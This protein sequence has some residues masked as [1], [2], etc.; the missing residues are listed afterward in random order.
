MGVED[1]QYMPNRELYL[2][3]KEW[4]FRRGNDERSSFENRWF[5][6]YVRECIMQFRRDA[7]Q[8]DYEP[9]KDKLLD[10]GA[11]DSCDEAEIDEND[12][13]AGEIHI[14]IYGDEVDD[15]GEIENKHQAQDRLGNE[16]AEGKKGGSGNNN[17]GQESRVKVDLGNSRGREPINT[18][19]HTN[20]KEYPPSGRRTSTRKGLE[21]EDESD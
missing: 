3:F 11:P 1:G 7:L 13:K 2:E 17:R 5:F 6:Y 9:W 12:Q 15:G 4:F 16:R 21:E 19:K 14:V 20:R 18:P 10:L 8:P